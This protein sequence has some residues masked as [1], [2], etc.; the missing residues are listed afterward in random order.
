MSD[1]IILGDDGKK[2]RVIRYDQVWQ[3]YFDK[4]RQ[5]PCRPFY[6]TDGGDDVEELPGGQYLIPKLGIVG[7]V[8]NEN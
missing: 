5:V 6:K 7:R 2:Y 3:Q 8:A 1:F 4:P